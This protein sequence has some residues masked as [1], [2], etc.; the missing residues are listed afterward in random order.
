MS[1]DIRGEMPEPVR[2]V[3]WDL[4]GTFWAGTLSEGGHTYVDAN[5][6]IVIELARR[7]IVSAICS[8]NDYE[9]VKAVLVEKGIWEYFV[10]PSIDW[11]PKGPRL[12]QLVEQVQL[13]PETIL[14][15]DDNPLNLREAEYFVPGIQTAPDSFIAEL[16]DSPLMRGKDDPEMSRLKQYKLLEARKADEVAAEDNTSFLRSCDIRVEIEQ[17]L[18]PHL[19][20][21]VELINRTN[22]L[23]FTKDRLPE[24]PERAKKK[25]RKLLDNFDVQAGLV[26]VRDRYGDYGYCGFYLAKTRKGRSHLRQFCFSCRILNM[27]VEHWLYQRL[28]RPEIDV[29]G[30]VLSDLSTPVPVD[31]INCV[32]ATGAEGANSGHSKSALARVI[33]RGACT[34][35]PLVHYFHMDA[36]EVVGEFNEVRDSIQ[37]RLDHSLFLRYAIEGVTT[38]QMDILSRLGFREADFETRFDDYTHEPAIRILSNW[39]DSQ[40]IIYRHRD[41]GF[42]VPWKTRGLEKEGADFDPV[43]TGDGASSST[44]ALNYL[45]DSF[46]NVGAWDADD[47]DRTLDLILDAVPPGSPLFVIAAPEAGMTRAVRTHA[48]EL[49][50]RMRRAAARH[51]DKLIEFVSIEDL[52]DAGERRS[53]QHFERAVYYKLYREITKRYGEIVG[54]AS[55]STD[56]AAESGTGA[57]QDT[58]HMLPASAPRGSEIPTKG[59][60]GAQR[61]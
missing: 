45:Q 4:D 43:P 35:A 48:A 59:T 32:A 33:I 47:A 50:Q 41:T 26:R 42:L 34:V 19:D 56:G 18:E 58:A 20:R 30:E 24:N 11:T 25:L 46:E 39:I 1:A 27:G 17:E 54:S 49:N 13:R 12:K 8:K 15:L 61:L 10:F 52:A 14:L 5:H 57:V 23:N 44:E 22:Q 6:E 38:E 60:G 21:V 2:L 16:L 3:V 9:T 29:V 51:P 31:W 7:G 55:T 40:D 37:I 28:G 36:A 53:G